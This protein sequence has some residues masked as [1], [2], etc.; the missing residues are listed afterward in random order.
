MIAP[1]KTD[2]QR[3][4]GLTYQGKP[5][6]CGF[7]FSA[8]DALA[9]VA[10]ALAAYAASF[11]I[12]SASLVILYV[13]VHFFLFC[14]VFRLRRPPELIWTGIFLANFALWM[15]VGEFDITRPL[16][17][18]IPVTILLIVMECRHATYHGVLSRRINSRNIERYLRGEI[19]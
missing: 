11:V 9:I 2:A 5:R 7:R 17:A 1:E 19:P 18:Q 4:A 12:G 13:L 14:N 15:S 8:T 3:V 6:T 16:L 10:F